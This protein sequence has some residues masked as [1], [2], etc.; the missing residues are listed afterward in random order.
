MGEILAPSGVPLRILVVD[1]H[2]LFRAGLVLLLSRMEPPPAVVQAG[3]VAEA[4][5]LARTRECE[6]LGLVLLDVHLQGGTALDSLRELIAAFP[7]AAVMIL[8]AADSPEVMREARAKG[9]R[10]Y[11]LKSAAPD[12]M[13]ESIAR[14]LA[15]ETSFPLPVGGHVAGPRLTGRQMEV[16]RLLCL[17]R[18]NKE[19][20]NQLGMSDN[21]VRTHLAHIFRGLE[22][23]TRTEASLAARCLGLV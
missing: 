20:A 4:L 8:S 1:D 21:T 9:A 2:A 16:L 14:V 18:T 12:V 11:I 10:G 23:R 6:G 17:G 19:I 22:V 5:A 13:L 3:S 15:G 7:F